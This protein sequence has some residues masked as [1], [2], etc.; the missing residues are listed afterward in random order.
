MRKMFRTAADTRAVKSLR[1]GV[2][3]IGTVMTAFVLA[4]CGVPLGSAVGIGVTASGEP[5][6][7]VL[8]CQGTVDTAMLRD[9]KTEDRYSG[10]T[11]SSLGP[12]SFTSFTLSKPGDGWQPG[13]PLFAG[14][15][16]GTRYV[17]RASGGQNGHSNDE[18]S[19]TYVYL[20]AKQVAALKPGQVR[21]WAGSTV[22]GKD[23]FETVTIDE[24]KAKGCKPVS[25]D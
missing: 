21:Y 17:F 8:V 22:D 11:A 4:G 9:A 10:W 19:S 12:G 3:G 2:A 25:G 20:D 16:V 14:L 15:K 13:D 7:Y 18:W 23:L 5:V 24:F 6:G 1:R